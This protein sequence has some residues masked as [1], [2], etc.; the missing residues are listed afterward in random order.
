MARTNSQ[1]RKYQRST[2]PFYAINGKSSI[3]GDDDEGGGGGGDTGK[4]TASDFLKLDS[5]QRQP[6]SR[7]WPRSR[8]H[9]VGT[10][11]RH[12]EN[13]FY[14]AQTQQ[15]KQSTSIILI[16]GGGKVSCI[17]FHHCY[18]FLYCYVH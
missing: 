12:N 5:D 14:K 13:P 4:R 9:V 17:Y 18:F 6:N 11:S 8:S 3:H 16:D 15:Q 10:G 2:M 7:G 1:A